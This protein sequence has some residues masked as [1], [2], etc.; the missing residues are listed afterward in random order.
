MTGASQ[1][2][3]EDG[4]AT[5]GAWTLGSTLG[6][7][8]LEARSPGL[9]GSPVTFHATAGALP[10][11]ATVEVHGDYFLSIRNGSGADPGLFGSVAVDTIGV[12]GTVAW[13]WKDSGHNVTAYGNS[14]FATSGTHNAPFTF[15]P[16]RSTPPARIPTG[17]RS[18][19]R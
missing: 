18:T 16:S 1:T 17:A 3:G 12:G 10:A 19:A 15:G 11:E 2:T 8:T 4:V 14:A 7:N 13:R 6:A 5:V 9:T